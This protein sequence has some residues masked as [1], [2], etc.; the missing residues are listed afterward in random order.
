M[1]KDFNYSNLKLGIIGGGQLGKIMSQKAK[2]VRRFSQ[3]AGEVWIGLA[4]YDN[5]DFEVSSSDDDGDQAQ[6]RVQS[7]SFSLSHRS[8]NSGANDDEKSEQQ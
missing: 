7:V 6:S 5:S 3:G 2:K 1:N 8:G 4:G